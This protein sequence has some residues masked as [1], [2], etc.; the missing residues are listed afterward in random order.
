MFRA[1]SNIQVTFNLTYGI[2]CAITW[3][4]RYLNKILIFFGVFPL[5]KHC[6]SRF[7]SLHS[8]HIMRYGS[9]TCSRCRIILKLLSSEETK[10]YKFILAVIPRICETAKYKLVKREESVHFFS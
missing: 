5:Q 3:S 8:L 1:I 10:W 4:K 9:N 6:V 2:K 7:F